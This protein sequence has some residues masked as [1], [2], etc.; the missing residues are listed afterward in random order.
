MPKKLP[1]ALADGNKIQYRSL[2][3]NG[4]NNPIPTAFLN[5]IAINQ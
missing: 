2:K 1:F 4:N 3:R 5:F